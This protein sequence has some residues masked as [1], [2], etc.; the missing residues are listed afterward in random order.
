MPNQQAQSSKA[1][2]IFIQSFILICTLFVCLFCVS[3]TAPQAQ[4]QTTTFRTIRVN[5]VRNLQTRH[6][7]FV[8]T[9]VPCLGGPTRIQLVN[10]TESAPVIQLENYVR[11]VIQPYS[12]QT[13]VE[14]IGHNSH[15]VLLEPG[16]LGGN[17]YLFFRRCGFGYALPKNLKNPQPDPQP[18]PP[19][20]PP[21]YRPPYQPQ[22]P[23]YNPYH[24]IGAICNDMTR[25]FAIGRGACSFHGGVNHWL[26]A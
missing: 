2:S 1:L 23:I 18:A 5:I 12:S 6:F 7:Y 17:A 16:Y 26:Y 9:Y 13:E 8:P 21:P 25:S 4:A 3:V 11:I 15:W 24:R 10:M 20:G 22:P 14:Y 19:P